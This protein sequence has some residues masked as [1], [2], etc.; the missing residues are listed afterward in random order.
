MPQLGSTTS[1]VRQ[2][3]RWARF[4][5]QVTE[6]WSE[7]GPAAASVAVPF[8][9]VVYLALQGG[10]YDAILRG[11]VGVAVWWIVLLASLVGIFPLV[12]LS[13]GAQA[14][15]GLLVAFTV[16]T[17]FALLWTESSERT[18]IEISRAATYVGVL[19]LAVFV[20]GPGSLRRTVGAVAAACALVGTLALLSR[21]HPSWF[22]ENETGAVI[23]YAKTRLNYPINYWNGL[24]YLIA[25]GMPLVLTVAIEARRIA[26]QAAMTAVTP[27]LALACFYTISRGGAIALIVAVATLVAIHPRRLF[28][29]PTVGLAIA[30]SGLLIAA[31]T[32]RDQLEDARTGAVALHQGDQMI[33]VVLVV[34]IG[35]GLIRVGI[36]L[37]GRHGV[38]RMPQVSRRTTLISWGVATAIALVIGLAAGAPGEISDTWQEFKA[39]GSPAAGETTG[40][41]AS[42]SG[43]GRYQWWGAAIEANATDPLLG[44]GPGTFEFYW[45][46]AGTIP[47]FI[48]D[49]HSLYLETL[50]ELGV[51]GATII[52]ALV[53][54]TL[55][56]GFRRSLRAPPE[57]RPWAAAATA[58]CAGFAVAAAADWAWELAVLPVMFLCLAAA[59]LSDRDEPD[60]P[61]AGKGATRLIFAAL[62]VLSLV[63][64]GVPLIGERT[65]RSSQEAAAA[66][67][68]SDAADRADAAAEIEPWAATPPLQQALVFAQQ[69]R[70]GQAATAA[71]R[72]TQ[73]EPTNWRPWYVLSQIE[74]S[75]GNPD[76]SEQAYD[77]ARSLNPRS[78][79]FAQ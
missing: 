63:A 77:K 36:G 44:I 6:R 57:R 39:P 47:G 24:A 29:L 4:A 20:Q 28:A 78:Y 33:A 71:R 27:I 3:T 5:H 18:V 26:T 7:I 59:L 51:I 55:G 52:F 32:Q 50:G 21:L 79:L 2:R 8:V 35:V 17:A 38:L 25:I 30:G 43:N 62:A 65:L 14:A 48:R 56:F 19:T 49:A 58:G 12:R 75:R 42:V 31:A 60:A 16:W 37:A 45:A 9:L 1:A 41:F 73:E 68:L 15:L 74:N 34:C 72:A 64:V 11:E 66:Q 22:P 61:A 10:G 76:A 13:R 69:H 40:R 53:F 46:R 54:G 23:D 67:R 70:L